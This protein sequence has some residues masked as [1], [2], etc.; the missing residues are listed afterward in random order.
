MASIWGPA[1]TV[2]VMALEVAVAERPLM[3]EDLRVAPWPDPDLGDYQGERDTEGRREGRGKE[4]S[5][6]SDPRPARPHSMFSPSTRQW[7]EGEELMDLRA[8][9]PSNNKADERPWF[10]KDIGDLQSLPHFTT[11][12]D[13]G[14][15]DDLG[16]RPKSVAG[17]TF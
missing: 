2:M 15:G 16:K 7:G 12:T 3:P 10:M 13:S 1:V 6:S 9:P 4:R 8:G 11:R 17:C 14:I 5:R